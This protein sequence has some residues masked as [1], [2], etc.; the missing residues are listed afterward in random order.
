MREMFECLSFSTTTT[1]AIIHDQGINSLDEVCILEPCDVETLCKTIRPPSG[2]IR[3]GNEDVPNPSISVS[4]LAESNL[5]IAAWYLMHM[6]SHIQCPKEPAEVTHEAICP[7]CE[8]MHNEATYEPPTD[9]LKIDD[10]D[11]AKTIDAMEEHL[12]LI[13]G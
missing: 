1:K 7:F 5:K 8:Q 9:L 12:H 10:H 4:A 3:R 6:Y 11:W 13:L 2:T